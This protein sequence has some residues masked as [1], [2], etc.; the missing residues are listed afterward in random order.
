MKHITLF[1]TSSL[2]II[3]IFILITMGLTKTNYIVID[4]DFKKPGFMTTFYFLFVFLLIITMSII[5]IVLLNDGEA[6]HNALKDIPDVFGTKGH[7]AQHYIFNGIIF[8][9]VIVIVLVI[10]LIVIQQETLYNTTNDKKFSLVFCFMVLF[11]VAYTYENKEIHNYVFGFV[12]SILA[13]FDL[14][15][16][17]LSAILDSILKLF[18]NSGIS[19]NS[20]SSYIKGFFVTIYD[21]IM[22]VFDVIRNKINEDANVKNEF[23]KQLKN[24]GIFLSFFSLSIIALFFANNDNRS[25]SN[26]MYFYTFLVVVP[27]ILGMYMSSMV[28]LEN[29][30]TIYEKIIIII[31]FLLIFGSAYCYSYHI[32]PFTSTYIYSFGN[33][34]LSLIVII[35][36]GITFIVFSDYLKKQRGLLGFIVNL[37]F[38]IPCLFT[39]F[40]EYIKQQI[41]ITPNIV[42]VMFILELLVIITYIYLPSMIHLLLHNDSVKLKK[43]PYYLKNKNVVAYNDVFKVNNNNEL[44][45]KPYLNNN[46]SFSFWIYL[47][48]DSYYA[49]T[50]NK[51]LNEKNIFD[52]A[53]GRPKLVYINDEIHNDV[54][55]FYLSNKCNDAVLT[56]DNPCDSDKYKT[57]YV[58]F[59]GLPKQRWNFIVINYGVNTADVFVNG[60]IKGSIEFNGENIPNDINEKSVVTIGDDS[61]L[62]GAIKEIYYYKKALSKF[63]IVNMYNLFNTFGTY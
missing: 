27:I 47:N 30:L 59:N 5:N 35:F 58:E 11:Y 49:V 18:S 9:S 33:V 22:F 8:S 44:N 7:S 52:F 46:Y 40:V 36:L 41:G 32:N 50:N 26:L 34:F 6:E 24:T 42:Y 17:T 43:N 37:I 15:K 12:L 60:N 20:L 62:D 13:I 10:L 38:F 14:L 21:N 48:S 55:R 56:N 16:Y 29:D 25:N 1:G 3:V 28:V 39:D 23:Y 31:G 54:Y 61:A 53:N 57:N 19:E 63:E 2:W 4:T 51:S 45:I